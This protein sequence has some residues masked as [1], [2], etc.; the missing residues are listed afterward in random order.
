[1]NGIAYH[2]DI[3]DNYR[4]KVKRRFS[5]LMQHRNPG[6]VGQVRVQ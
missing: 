5:S 4:I 1:L 2:T 6:P 3:S